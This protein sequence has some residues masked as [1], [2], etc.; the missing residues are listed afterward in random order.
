MFKK[1]PKSTQ[2]ELFSGLSQQVGSKKSNYLDNTA[3][4]HNIYFSEITSRIDESIFAVLYPSHTGRSNAPIRQLLGMMILKEGQNWSD[5]QLFENSCYNLIVMRALGLQNLTDEPPV[6]STY[7]DFKSKLRVYYK[8]TGIDLLEQ[9]FNKLTQDQVVRYEVSGR[10]IRMDSKLIASNIAKCTRLQLVI[11]TVQQFYKELKINAQLDWLDKEQDKL[12]KKLCS[13]AADGHTY[14]LKNAEKKEMLES[15]GR[16]IQ[17]LLSSC[18]DKTLSSYQ[19]LSRLFSEHYEL[20]KTQEKGDGGTLPPVLLRPAK[21]LSGQTIQSPFDDEATYRQKKSGDKKQDVKGYSSNITENCTPG[22]LSLI[23]DAQIENAGTNDDQYLKPALDTVE[24]VTGKIPDE[25]ATD[26]AYNSQ[27][28][29]DLIAQKQKDIKWYLT[30]IQG[31]AGNFDFIWNEE[32]QLLVTDR[33]TGKTQIGIKAH[34]RASTKDKAPRY[35][36]KDPDGS[37][38][39]IEQK[40]IKTYF[41]RQEILNLPEEIRNIRPNVEATIHQ[42]FYHLNGQQSKYRGLVAHRHMVFARCFWTNCRRITAKITQK[43]KWKTVFTRLCHFSY[44][45]VS[46]RNTGLVLPNFALFQKQPFLKANF[47][48]LFQRTF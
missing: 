35:R 8:E 39:Y 29:L 24:K 7:Y 32:G 21:E 9:A 45:E 22:E 44:C 31:S 14:P 19:T 16:L 40:A 27:N 6:A 20:K 23:L 37:K 34:T 11:T 38:R 3:G 12:L 18:P 43:G 5:E 33:R 4:W 48:R 46:Y 26:G 2:A 41:R 17:K 25:I 36:I 30:A 1:S 42:V 10:R 15:L 28:N 47:I 13:K